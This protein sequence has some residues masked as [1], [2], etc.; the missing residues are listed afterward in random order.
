MVLWKQK[1]QQDVAFPKRNGWKACAALH[2]ADE[3]SA[4]SP[5]P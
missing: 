4:W 3:V 1:P 2:L 5:Q